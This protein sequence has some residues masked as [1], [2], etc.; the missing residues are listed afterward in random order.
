VSTLFF[1]YSHADESLRDQLEKH[2]SSLQRQGIISSWHDRRI[3]A[4][5]LVKARKQSRDSALKE[6]DDV[7]AFGAR[8]M[9]LGLEVQFRIFSASFV[10]RNL[11][12]A[13]RP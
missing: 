10:L 5:V 9:M 13:L 1:S 3:A 11:R 6:L 4:G 2:L 12:A 7:A 8:S